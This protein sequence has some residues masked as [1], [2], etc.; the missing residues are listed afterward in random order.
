[1]APD[2]RTDEQKQLDAAFPPAKP[3]DY[4]IR[5]GGPGEGVKETP[6]LKPF[7]STA[8]TWLSKAQFPREVGNSLVNAIAQ[9][10]QQTQAMTEGQ[11]ESYGYAEFAKLERAYGNTLD[12]RLR[13]AGRIVE[14]LEQKQPGLKNLLKSKGIGDNA[15]I[16][17][18]L[19]QQAERYCARRR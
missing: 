1:L 19:I 5:Y 7:D 11:L 14:A 13:Q 15:M 16:A 12:E 10:A 17:S 6:E 8:R 4:I 18:L 9:V 3:G 2:Q